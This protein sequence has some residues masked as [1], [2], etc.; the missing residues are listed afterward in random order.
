MVTFVCLLLFAKLVERNILFPKFDERH[1]QRIQNIF[2]EKEQTLL[3]YMDMLGQCVWTVGNDSCFVNFHGK[4]EANLKKHGLYLFVYRNDTLK[5]WS[6][7][8]VAVPEAYSSSEFDRPYVSLGDNRYAS[9]K[10]ASFVKKG[11]GY[12]I[13]G[14]ALIKNIY[15]Y[16]NKYLKIAFQEDFGLPANVKISS[17]QVDDGYPITDSRDRFVWSLIFDSTCTY[18]YQIHVPA[19]A[20]LLA[21]IV[22]FMLLNSVFNVLRTSTSRNIYLPALVLIL[23]G[24]R[25]AMQHWKIPGVFYELELFNPIYFG[26]AWFPSFGELCLW[27]IFTCFFVF[28]LYRYLR[29]PLFYGRRWKYFAYLGISLMIVIVGFFGMGVL[30]K[31]LVINSSDIFEG[32]NRILLLNGFSLLGYAVIMLFLASFCLL[33]DKMILLC[34]QEL[35]FQQFL[36]AYVI[37]LSIVVIG[38][39]IAGLYVSLASVFFLTVLVFMAGNLRLKRTVKFKYSH[40][41]LLIFILTLFTSVYINRYS[42]EKYEGQKK[43]LVTNLAPQHDLTAEFLLRNISDRMIADTSALVDVVYKD[44]FATTDYPNVVNYIKK[45]YFFSSYWNKYLIRGCWVSSDTTKLLLTSEQRKVNS[46]RYFKKMTDDMGTKLT[47]SEFWLIDRPYVSTYLGWFLVTKEGEP[48]LQLFIE[49]VPSGVASEEI[50]YPELLLDDR[51]AKS[52]NLKGYSY[53]KYVN[54]RRETQYGD[55]KYN[56]EGDIFQTGESD[57]H[58]VYADDMEHLVYR[59]EKNNMIVLSSY[60]PKP[61]DLVIKFSYIF[62]FFFIVVSVCLLIFYLPV[63]RRGFQWNFRN[64]IQYSMIAVMLVSLAV[65]G[66]FTIISVNR[67]YRNKNIDIVNEKMKAIHAELL[68]AILFQRNLDDQSDESKDMLAGWLADFRRLFF[69]DINLFDVHGQ[70]IATSLPDIFDKG[71]VG[72]QISPNAYIQLA[73]GQRASIIENEEIGGLHYI[74]AY[75]PFVDNDNRVIAFLN[76]PYF[77]QQDALSEEISNIVI[78]LLNFYMV[79][80]L[81][82]VIVSVVMSNQITQPLMMLQEKFRDIRL[83]EKNEPILYESH[84]EVGGLV[85]EYNRAIEELAR[86]ANRLARSERESAWREMAKQ[87][88]HEINNPLTPMKLSIQHLKRAYDNKSERF[89]MYMEK[90]SRSLVEQIDTLSAI[91]TE[92]SNFAKMP[93]AQNELI[94]L[95]D[96]IN[97]VVPLFAIDDNRRAFHT[98]FHGLERTMICAD[99]EQ[100]SRV[101]INLFKNALQ[102]I[103][104]GRQAEIHIDVLK[105]NRIVWV[106]IKDNGTGIPAE[107]QEKI[108]RPNFTTKSSGMGV[109][110]SI[111]RSIIESAGGSINFKT[112]QNEGTTFMISLPSA[113]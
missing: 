72:R 59:P 25:Y 43:I 99:R 60:S 101:F 5:Y 71:L 28:E 82:T 3:H 62:I 57:Y 23:A 10:Y 33:L 12:E 63:I 26:T 27:C 30:L 36:I 56:L 78:A 58:T 75:E 95:I 90:I 92:F 46:V 45:Q 2:A 70:L 17:R 76:L 109:G 32:P 64:K 97:N 1:A 18:K 15:T 79:I 112:R 29:F 66:V 89:D 44:Y 42:Y 81:L 74:S 77:T 34:K 6:T 98:D 61:G 111:V 22:L 39:S 67:Q 55:Y 9:G 49:L 68:D 86:S 96:K 107:M 54:N 105:I 11:D 88:A 85:K 8:N 91:A 19:L 83:G 16:E 65:I 37:I 7:M 38:W 4:Y 13:V 20:Y 50:G 40:Y 14:L 51:L 35:N 21:I 53:A 102:A 106:R 108:F 52:N 113:D 48:P 80:V 100:M 69:T 24:V 41:I 103:P 94:D 110:L 47:R 87:I 31:S 73:F 93:A 104:K 84:D